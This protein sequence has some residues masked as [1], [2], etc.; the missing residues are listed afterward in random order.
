MIMTV[1][2]ICTMSGVSKTTAAELSYDTG[3]D[4]MSIMVKSAINN[5]SDTGVKAAYLRNQKIDE[6]GL[7]NE[8]VEFNQEF[9]DT[10]LVYNS[11]GY[12]HIDDKAKEEAI[13]TEDTTEIKIDYMSQIIDA[14]AVGDLA[15]AKSINI[16][17]DGVIDSKGLTL[18]KINIDDL[19]NISKIVQAEAGSNWI[20]NYHQQCVANV[21]INRV[22][23]PEF[24][25]TVLDCIY[26]PGQY[27]PKGSRYFATIIPTERA[28]T[29][30]LY[31]LEGNYV[32]PPSVVFQANFSQGS[33]TFVI[34]SARPL[35]DSYFCYSS[36]TDLYPEHW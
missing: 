18:K 14:L 2:V 21:L 11:E 29:N 24:K 3:I 7:S 26:S 34:V 16:T 27:Y 36:H 1:V 33:G 23:G 8:K 32:L 22:I 4:Y 28:I 20:T 19:Y 31:V 17:R 13:I 9:V 6:L 25:D 5:D 12:I 30:A 15:T 10:I 35:A